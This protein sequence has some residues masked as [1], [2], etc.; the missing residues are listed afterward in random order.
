MYLVRDGPDDYKIRSECHTMLLQDTQVCDL[1]VG[2][3]GHFMERN[4]RLISSA[5]SCALGSEEYIS[6]E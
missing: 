6:S 3:F 5:A 1:V 2:K 4:S